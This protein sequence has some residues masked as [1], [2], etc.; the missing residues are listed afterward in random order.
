MLIATLIILNIPI[1][2]FIGWLVFDTKQ[3]AADT[4]F[5]TIVALL[6][7]TAV[8][9]LESVARVGVQVSL[10]GPHGP[11]P[12]RHLE[13]LAA[14]HASGSVSGAARRVGL[15]YRSAWLWVEQLNAAWGKPLVAKIQGGPGGGGAALSPAA[16]GLLELARRCEQAAGEG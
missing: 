4:F 8:V 1:Y 11:L 16:H 5:D 15:S 3:G 6:K 13:L 14:I 7:A 2:L 9:P 10:V 12:A